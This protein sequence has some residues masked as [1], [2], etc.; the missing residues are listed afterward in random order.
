[1]IR[2][3]EACGFSRRYLEAGVLLLLPRNCRGDFDRDA[4]ECPFTSLETDVAE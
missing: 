4:H 3:E 1:M 2:V